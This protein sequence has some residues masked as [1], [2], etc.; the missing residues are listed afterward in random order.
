MLDN[1]TKNESMGDIA[2]QINQAGMRRKVDIY[3]EYIQLRMICCRTVVFFCFTHTYMYLSQMRHA[4]AA[5]WGLS[6]KHNVR[7]QHPVALVL[8]LGKKASQ[9]RVESKSK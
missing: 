3:L 8:A 1:N 2:D 9:Q 4:P 5:D 6:C 7:G